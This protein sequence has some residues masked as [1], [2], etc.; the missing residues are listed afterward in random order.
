MPSNPLAAGHPLTELEERVKKLEEKYSHL[1]HG[2]DRPDTPPQARAAMPPA[3]WRRTAR[4]LSPLDPNPNLIW[5]DP[6]VFVD[7]RPIRHF[8]K[9]DGILCLLP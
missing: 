2:E 5:T 8:V 7:C 3:G 1:L 4:W 9:R 6:V